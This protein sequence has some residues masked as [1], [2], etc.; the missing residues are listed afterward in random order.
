MTKKDHFHEQV[1]NQHLEDLAKRAAKTLMCSSFTVMKLSKN[2]E[3]VQRVFTSD[4]DVF[5]LSDIKPTEPNPWFEHVIGRSEIFVANNP[6]EMGGQF[7]DLDKMLA[8]G[9]AAVMN[10]PVR[11]DGNVVAIINLLAPQDH[12]NDQRLSSAQQFTSL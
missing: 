7:K 4:N 2:L 11:H 6:Q 9:F 12:F 5:P 10:V 3:F 8:L 1:S